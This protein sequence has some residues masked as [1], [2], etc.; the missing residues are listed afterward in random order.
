[1]RWLAYQCLRLAGWRF[2]GELP[3]DPKFVV[4][5]AP[6]TSNWDFVVFMAALSHFRL[7]TRFLAK[8]GLFRWPFG[9]VLR[10][11]GGIPVGGP[12]DAGV[13]PAAVAE[14]ARNEEMVLVIAPEGT[15]ARAPHWKLGF[16]AIAEQAGVPIVLAGLDY[17]S[18]SVTVGPTIV[19]DGDLDVIMDTARRFFA[20][21]T[22]LHRELEGPVASP[23]GS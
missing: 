9:P 8:R 20:D 7:K 22:G 19:Y 16:V 21:M 17:P 4:A 18:K 13:V 11:L 1:M 3:P 15:R 14:F 6:H 5:G 10:A 12:Q 2:F 23:S